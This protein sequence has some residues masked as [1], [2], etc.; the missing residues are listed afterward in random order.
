MKSIRRFVIFAA[1]ITL[2]ACATVTPPTAIT[3]PTKQST[4]VSSTAS[5]NETVEDHSWLMKQPCAAPCWEGITPGITTA[6]EAQKLLQMNGSFS[7]VSL[8]LPKKS[9]ERSAVAWNWNG[10]NVSGEADFDASSPKHV[11]R[12]VVVGFITPVTLGDVTAAYGYPNYVSSEA[13][14]GDIPDQ[15]TY[16]LY[17]YY[18]S[19]GF[20]LDII[21]LN[22]TMVKPAITL[23]TP[24][25]SVSFFSASIDGLNIAL[26]GINTNIQDQLIP[27][28]GTF[29]F[30]TYCRL[31]Y[32]SDAIWHCK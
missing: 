29:D 5:T 1:S 28:Q 32:K 25:Y 19:S 13:Q 22:N 27:W 12:K 10:T 23:E 18:I 15:L 3:A 31:Q 20:Y 11:L 24:I 26:G 21:N 7:D 16:D 2:M 8:Y 14:G 4:L 17:F 9:P 6:E 30:D